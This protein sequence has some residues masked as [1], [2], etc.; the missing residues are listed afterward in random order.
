MRPAAGSVWTLRQASSCGRTACRGSLPGR[1]SAAGVGLVCGGARTD[2]R[3]AAV[4]V[5]GDERGEVVA[6]AGG[7]VVG[8]ELR[9]LAVDHDAGR[10]ADHLLDDRDAVAERRDVARDVVVG[11]VR[12]RD[13]QVVLAL[14]RR[15]RRNHVDLAGV[16]HLGRDDR[17]EPGARLAVDRARRRTE[18]VDDHVRLGEQATASPRPA[19]R[20]R[21]ATRATTRRRRTG[22]RSC[23][24]RAIPYEASGRALRSVSFSHAALTWAPNRNTTPIRSSQSSSTKSAESAP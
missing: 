13:R 19:G 9:A 7:F 5:A 10:R 4:R 6:L 15:R 23:G 14:G 2:R 17:R 12:A 22:P 20:P 3:E 21:N 8:V 1:C 11:V 24:P 18:R 16:R